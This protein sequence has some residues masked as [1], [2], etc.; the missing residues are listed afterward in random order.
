MKMKKTGKTPAPLAK[1]TRFALKKLSP[2]LGRNELGPAHRWSVEM[3]LSSHLENKFS[4]WSVNSISSPKGTLIPTAHA[5]PPTQSWQAA[6][7]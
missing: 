4:E 6:L 1:T 5:K 2:A 7:L 3:E